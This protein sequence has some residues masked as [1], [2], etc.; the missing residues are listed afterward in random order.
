MNIKSIIEI[1]K[2]VSLPHAKTPMGRWNIHNNRKTALKIK[3]ATEDNCFQ[4]YKGIMQTQMQ[5][6]E[7]NELARDDEYMYMMGYESVHA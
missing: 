6:E 3:Y 2:L 4:N 5:E 1:F 7:N